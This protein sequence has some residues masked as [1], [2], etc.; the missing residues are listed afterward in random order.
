MSGY[1]EELSIKVTA[2]DEASARLRDVK[3]EL[4]SLE[5][6]QKDAAR[7]FYDTGAKEA[8]ADM[9]RLATSIKNL[10]DE[11]KK[12]AAQT[13]RLKREI[14]KLGTTR[15]QRTGDWLVKHQKDIQ[16]AGI[17]GAAAM[18]LFARSSIKAFIE[19][20]KQSQRL[21]AA[22]AKFPKINDVTIESFQELNTEL[23]NMTGADDDALAAAEGT[24]AMFDLTGKQ[25]Q[26]LIPLVNDYAIASGRDVPEAAEAIGKALLGNTRALKELGIDYKA[27]GDRGRDLAGVMAALEVKVGGVGKAF[28]Q[29]AAGQAAIAEQNFANLQEEV[30]RAL[31]PALQGLVSIL[32][33]VVAFFTRLP[34]PVKQAG[35]AVTAF[36]LASMIALPRII[37]L[38]GAIDSGTISA[39]SFK[40]G[41]RG[42]AGFL[43]SP[44]GLALAAG[45]LALG[46]FMDQA[47]EA[48]A[49]VQGFK[50]SIDAVTGAL[51]ATGVAK[52]SEQLLLDISAEDWA[53][54][55]RYGY[56]VEQVTAA[57][58]GGQ[59]AWEAF[60]DSVRATRVGLDYFNGDRGLLST[61]QNNAY[62]LRS[63]V[64]R[65]RQAFDA[66]GKAA[67]IAGLDYSGLSDETEELAGETSVAAVKITGMALALD[68]LT[69]AVSRQRA[70][71]AFN[72]SLTDFAE[73]PSKEG[74]RDVTEAYSSALAA[75]KNPKKAAR[76]AQENFSAVRDAIK[77]SGMSESM[78]AELL[79]PLQLVKA[80]AQGIL[81]LLENI[82][83]KTVN[84]TI[85]AK[86]QTPGM[87]TIL[88]ADGGIV[89]GPG[90]GTSDSI[91]AMLSNG[92]Y[93][94]RAAAVDRIGL[95]TLDRLNIADRIPAL[96]PIVNAPSITLPTGPA[97]RDA[98]LIGHMEVHPATA[99]D[100]QLELQRAR[101]HED[102]HRRAT[103][104]GSR[105]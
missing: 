78:Q 95:G 60:H 73:K 52:I 89:R 1:S 90:S 29:T 3:K 18:V 99:I 25:I 77:D 33:P 100:F 91:P 17:V 54:L 13:A 88:K 69:G 23:M 56:G 49:R 36:G 87:Q 4:R 44:W 83:G 101:R 82:D 26:A 10:R 35:F 59:P 65:G 76:F 12:A 24:L 103:T 105:R 30:G 38:K 50:D 9:D 80:E 68:R 20:E 86:L 98:P 8:K 92:E 46:H 42:T 51:N 84:A 37:A 19:A 5:Q 61:M 43:V 53:I 72:K 2:Q 45:G 57:I 63:E 31:V 48:D 97:G 21:V 7:A 74:A 79:G 40:R 41:L 27:T 32:R 67:S 39:G 75:F 66:A 28:G 62:G 14:D 85:I 64:D 104:A 11:Q 71:A 58:I 96:P 6:Q 22:Y 34:D 16:R 70:V 15:L 47:A 81:N 55:E 94:L 93:V 102:R